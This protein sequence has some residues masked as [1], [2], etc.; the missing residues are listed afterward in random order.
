MGHCFHKVVEEDKCQ[1]NAEIQIEVRELVSLTVITHKKR[2]QK[3]YNFTRQWWAFFVYPVYDVSSLS[4][5][6]V[7]ACPKFHSVAST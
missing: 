1:S 5:R 6:A 7:D 3:Q 2:P 4:F